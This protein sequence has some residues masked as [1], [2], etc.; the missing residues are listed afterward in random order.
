MEQNNNWY[1]SEEERKLAEQIIDMEKAALDK[2][3]K[4]D[5]SAYRALWSEDDFSYFDS[6]A[7]HRVDTHEEISAFVKSAV[8]GKLFADSYDFC[9]P[10]VQFGGDMAVLTYQLHADTTLINMHYNCIEVYRKQAAGWRVIHSTRSFIRPMDMDFGTIK[11]V[12]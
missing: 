12:V 4:G 11:A 3:F 7:D 5:S 9:N 10:R 8:D 1:K 2:W 6:V